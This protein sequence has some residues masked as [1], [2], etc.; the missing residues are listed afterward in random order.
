M[1]SKGRAGDKERSQKQ[2]AEGNRGTGTIYVPHTKQMLSDSLSL[3]C[4]CCHHNK[5]LAAGEGQS[6][7]DATLPCTGAEWGVSSWLTKVLRMANTSLRVKTVFNFVQPSKV[8]VWQRESWQIWGDRRLSI[9]G[10]ASGAGSH[11][12]TPRRETEDSPPSPSGMET[13]G[14]DRDP[15]LGA[16]QESS[17]HLAVLKAPVSHE[18]ELASHRV[19]SLIAVILHR[20]PER[21]DSPPLS[22]SPT[23]SQA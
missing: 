16:R 5:P 12:G 3:S 7:G 19:T 21:G 13:R 15:G 20:D 8:A 6:A 11:E 9:R 17:K 1:G 10:H 4:C 18:V 22:L 2:R 23:A 14:T